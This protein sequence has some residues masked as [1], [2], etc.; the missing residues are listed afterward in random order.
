MTVPDYES[1][2]R[3]MLALL[4]DGRTWAVRDI[5]TALCEY[6]DLTEEDKALLLPSGKAR[7]VNNRIGWANTYLAQAGTIERPARATARITNAGRAVLAAN[8]ERVDRRVLERF[9]AFQDFLSRSREEPQD[10]T[11]DGPS[12]TPPENAMPAPSIGRAVRDATDPQELLERATAE[13]AALVSGQLL[14]RLLT[15][16]PVAF[17]R[18]VLQVLTALGYG[19]R[20]GAVEQTGRTGDGGI[21]GIIRQDPLGLDRVYMQAKR[22]AFDNVVGRP[23]L[24]AFVGALHGQQADRGV[25][26]S[27]S[28]FSREALEYVRYLRERII[29]VDGRRLADLMVLNNVGV[30]DE[31]TFTL[32]R[33]DEDFFEAL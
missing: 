17:E 8:P 28:S 4:S 10:G 18:L 16:D 22:Y 31:Q 12:S 21:D 29:L 19:G 14:D 3:P 27:T 20:S 23:A 6:F 1:F 11:F 32:K 26:I 33:L 2:M 30:Q 25:F 5:T 9:D 7:L 24:Q 13:N 15:V